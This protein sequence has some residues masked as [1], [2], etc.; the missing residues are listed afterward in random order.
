MYLLR[1]FWSLLKWIGQIIFRVDYSSPPSGG[2]YIPEKQ[3]EIE[4]PD[5]SVPPTLS[6][7]NLSGGESRYGIYHINSK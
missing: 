1:R 4:A 6:E 3:S 7:H 2:A 5:D